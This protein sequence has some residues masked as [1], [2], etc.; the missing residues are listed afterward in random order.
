MF[1]LP[2]GLPIELTPLS[3]LVGSWEGTG[4]IA[5]EG[6]EHEFHQRIE[7]ADGGHGTLSYIST[8][9][10]DD[11]NKTALPSELGYWRVSRPREAF[12]AGPG[13]LPGIGE[14]TIK[15]HE[16]LEQY[17]NATGGFDIEVSTIHPGGSAE[18]YNGYVK[19]AQ[20]HLASAH[21]VAFESAKI[22]RHSTR[23]YGLVEG[24]LLWVWD[25]A[26]P[27]GELKSHASARLERVG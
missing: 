13:L 16:D 21:G 4:I 6:K 10:L 5:F 27:G 20:I 8:A 9:S 11:D 1:E 7:F 22:Y 12:D 25:I 14:T 24:A 26:M 15:T 19:L 2:E 17:R 18:L 23:I 3:F